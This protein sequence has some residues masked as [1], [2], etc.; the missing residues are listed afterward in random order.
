MKKIHLSLDT[1]NSANPALCG[2]R[3]TKYELDLVS[4]QCH[5]R[6]CQKYLFC[7]TCV[8]ALKRVEGY[9]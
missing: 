2:K 6:S 3:P 4:P 7:K 5:D 8:K 9:L 1:N